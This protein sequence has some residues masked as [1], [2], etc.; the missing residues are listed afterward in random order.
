MNGMNG[1]AKSFQHS[2]QPLLPNSPVLWSGF[3]AAISV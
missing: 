2:V 1:L 3:G